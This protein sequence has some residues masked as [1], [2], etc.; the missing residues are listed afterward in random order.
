MNHLLNITKKELRELL[1]VSSVVSILVVV[2]IMM[3]IGTMMSDQTESVSSPSEIGIVNGDI[4]PDGDFD[5][6]NVTYDVI[7]S[8]YE[9][10]YDL[11]LE[12]AKKYIIVLE[13]EFGD[14][15]SIMNEL[16]NRGI[17][18]ALGFGPEYSSTINT[19]INTENPG[20]KLDPSIIS[21][22]YVFENGGLIQMT[23]S[24]IAS[25]II[26]SIEN[27]ISFNIIH[28][29]TGNPYKTYFVMSPVSESDSQ[30]FTYINGGIH[31]GITPTE[32]SS[33]MMSQTLMI[34]V[35]IMIVI[36][37][38]GSIVISSMGNEK[39]NKTLETLLTLPVKR[40][41]IVSGKLIASAVTGLIFGLAYMVGMMFYMGGMTS[42]VS[43]VDLA[44]YGLS[45][46]AFDWA[47]I[48]AMVFMAIL[49]ALGLCMILGAFVKN[50]KAAQT[51]TLP[52]SVL[53]M[54]PMFVTMFS[55]WE[56]LPS[57]I[58]GV[59]FAIPFTHPMM[60]MENLMF[61][62]MTLVFAGLAYLIIF[63]FAA[64]YIT[65]KLYKSDILLTGLGQTKIAQKFGKKEKEDVERDR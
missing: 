6:Y 15:E 11:S 52:I 56:T 34:P 8:F 65:V 30:T 31:E 5:W 45:L 37:M 43:G 42:S 23:T 63:T 17:N 54:I 12:E 28:D 55:S 18:T 26:A 47:I 4:T 33:S 24:T 50:Y 9:T 25:S 1:T 14:N 49:C 44:E 38:I 46:D 13:S 60:V 62:N 16:Q 41:M 48:L 19:G 32:I 7:V 39:E 3:A 36:V 51:M 27:M 35:I 61:G 59:M 58:Q 40:T 21:E 2:I 53:A 20:K 64:I 10:N 57:V 29:I 22:Y